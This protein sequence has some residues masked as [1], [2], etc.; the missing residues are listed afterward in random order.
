MILSR[1]AFIIASVIMIVVVIFVLYMRSK[2][3]MYVPYDFNSMLH[4]QSDDVSCNQCISKYQNDKAGLCTCLK[5]N[6]CDAQI[7]VY[8][9]GKVDTIGA[10]DQCALDYGKCMNE[11]F[12]YKKC[13]SELCDCLKTAKCEQDLIDETCAALPPSGGAVTSC[14]P[15]DG[16][17]NWTKPGGGLNS[18]CCQPPDYQLAPEYTKISDYKDETDPIISSCLENCAKYVKK[19]AHN[20]DPSFYPMAACACSLCCRQMSKKNP[21]FT[22]YGTCVHYISG[23][24]AEANT[25]DSS[26]VSGNQNW[27]GWIGFNN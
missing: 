4:L 27:R 7:P 6:R 8:C 5:N 16:S 9:K 23:D 22:K 1:N 12:D 20:F 13:R 26:E 18:P 3:N 25:P 10:C 14:Q 15:A 17:G 19:Q 11:H 24:P 21:H 2:E